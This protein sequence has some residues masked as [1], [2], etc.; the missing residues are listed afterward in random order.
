MRES[1]P[2]NVIL[3]FSQIWTKRLSSERKPKPGWIASAPLTSVADIGRSMFIATNI[4]LV[5]N[6]LASVLGVALVFIRFLTAGSNP[7]AYLFLYMAFWALPVFLVSFF[8]SV[9]R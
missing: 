4:Y 6:L 1:G 5:L 7:L 9:K 8:V 2:M 3:H